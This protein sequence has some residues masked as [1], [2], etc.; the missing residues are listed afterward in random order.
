MDNSRP[1]FRCDVY[2]DGKLSHSNLFGE[3]KSSSSGKE[4]RYL[5]LYRILLFSKNT[6]DKK[7]KKNIMS[8][9]VVGQQ[10][11]VYMLDLWYDKIYIAVELYSFFLPALKSNAT[12]LVSVVEKLINI[13]NIYVTNSFE[14]LSKDLKKSSTLP[15][16]ISPYD[17]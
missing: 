16:V 5:D 13:H 17:K 4:G 3:V 6:I 1:D 10:V 8:F 12:M 14:E 11:V 9:R 15:V 2:E 7:N